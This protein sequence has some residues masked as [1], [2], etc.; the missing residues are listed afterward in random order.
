[1]TEK[2]QLAAGHQ[3]TG[4]YFCTFSCVED[5]LGESIKVVFG[6]QNNPAADAIVTAIWDYAR[7]ASLVLAASKGAKKADGSAASPEWKDKVQKTISRVFACNDDRKLLPHTLLQP[8][9]DGS[10]DLVRHGLRLGF[11]CAG[12]TGTLDNTARSPPRSS[13]GQAIH[14]ETS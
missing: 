5:T 12:R 10:V 4:A 13:R 6:L 9:P 11:V 14:G 8:N 1:M 2:S 3:M 7:K